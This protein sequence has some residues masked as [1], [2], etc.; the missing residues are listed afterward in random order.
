MLGS[1]RVVSILSAAA[2]ALG[3]SFGCDAASSWL[4][5][6]LVTFATPDRS[7]NESTA[8]E[9]VAT[10]AAR[11]L[12]LHVQIPR[13]ATAPNAYCWNIAYMAVLEDPLQAQVPVIRM[14]RDIPSQ[15]SS[16][17][18]PITVRVGSEE[19]LP[20]GG[21]DGVLYAYTITM[22]L[23]MSANRGAP[24]SKELLCCIMRMDA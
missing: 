19:L 9:Q 11:P 4:S 16:I 7:A 18:T 15:Y 12:Y 8:S 20:G 5:S 21:S 23:T 6:R 13:N 22:R 14:Y 24:V 3:S 1:P 2:A 10:P 17:Q